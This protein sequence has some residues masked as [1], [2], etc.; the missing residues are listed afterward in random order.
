VTRSLPS[1][2]ILTIAGAAVLIACGPRLK[3]VEYQ[4][5][6]SSGDST[7]DDSDL[8][9]GHKS[10]SSARADTMSASPGNEL[11]TGKGGPYKPCDETEKACGARCTEC[12][13]GNMNCME[14]LIEKQCNLEHKCV[15]A[16]V[17]CTVP[18]KGKKAKMSEKK[19]KK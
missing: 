14:V 10:K 12:A 6:P 18:E 19:K 1:F 3:P 5:P 8:S 2:R 11:G 15:A 9:S 4:P 13:P 7:P 17:D 16:P